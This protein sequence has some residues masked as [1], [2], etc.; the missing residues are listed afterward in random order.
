VEGRYSA[1][2][3]LTYVLPGTL[4]ATT[5]FY[6]WHGWPYGDPSVGLVVGIVAVGFFVGHVI[7]AAANWLQP[8]L[9]GHLPGRHLASAEGLFGPKG[10]W[11]FSEQEVKDAFKARFPEASNFESQFKLAYAEAQTGPLGSK[12]QTF[13][14][15][16]GFYR[17]G[18]LA[19]ALCLVLV[20]AFALTGRSHLPVSLWGPLF[21]L[22]FVAF[23]YRFRRFWVYLGDYVVRDVLRP[24]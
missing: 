7:A 24:R 11:T 23:A 18:A 5:A 20:T 9:W 21:L 16:I 6:G 15:Q 14:E 13:V 1:Y 4:V 19:C 17:S 2:E 22:S 8:A 12:L 3:Y 10:A